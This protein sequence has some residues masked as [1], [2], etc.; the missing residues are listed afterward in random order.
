MAS[1]I[2]FSLT[3]RQAEMLRDWK[4]EQSN[5]WRNTRV[6]GSLKSAGLVKGDYSNLQLTR[7]GIAAQL[8]AKQ[9]KLPAQGRG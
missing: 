4:K 7:T 9:L 2:V 6:L 5:Y 3:Q 8:L 1:P